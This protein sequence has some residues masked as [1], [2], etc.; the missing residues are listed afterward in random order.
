MSRSP[1][2]VSIEEFMLVRHYSKRTI[3]S[4]LIWIR[5]YILFHNKSHPKQ[6]GNRD[7]EAFL[8][9]LATHGKVPIGTQNFALNELNTNLSYLLAFFS[10]RA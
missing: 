3:R 7:I 8:T 4:Y 9:H 1:F 6:L 10:D 2:L 5:S